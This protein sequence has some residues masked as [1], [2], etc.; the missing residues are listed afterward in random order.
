MDNSDFADLTDEELRAVGDALLATYSD[1]LALLEPA[2]GEY[3]QWRAEMRR[4]RA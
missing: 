3:D 4:R 1:A 2:R